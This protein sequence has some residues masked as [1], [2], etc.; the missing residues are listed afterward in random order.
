MAKRI[1]LFDFISVDGHDI[2]NFCRSYNF[3]SEHEQVDVSG[4]S[5]SG[6]NESLAGQTVQSV[7]LEVFGSYGANEVYDILYPIHRDRSVVAFIHYPNQNLPVSGT[8]PQLSGNVQILTWAEGATRGEVE[9]FPVTLAAA[10]EDGLVY[11]DT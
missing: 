11:S 3:T 1:A 7:E 9:A 6:A 8:N 10:D 2:S 4:F 5:A